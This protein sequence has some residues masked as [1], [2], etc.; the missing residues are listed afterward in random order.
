MVHRSRCEPPMTV[1]P[2]FIDG[3][4]AKAGGLPREAPADILSEDEAMDWYEGYDS[5]FG[6]QVKAALTE[7]FRDLLLSIARSSTGQAR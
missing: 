4:R 6:E 7:P 2:H 5:I 1:R 3:A